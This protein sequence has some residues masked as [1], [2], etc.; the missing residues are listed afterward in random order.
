MTPGEVEQHLF[1]F[2]TE[3]CASAVKSGNG[4]V[5]AVEDGYAA[6]PHSAS[7]VFL[8]VDAVAAHNPQSTFRNATLAAML[9]DALLPTVGVLN[10]SAGDAEAW[11]L[12]AGYARDRVMAYQRCKAAALY[13]RSTSVSA[14]AQARFSR[15]SD[16]VRADIRS[17]EEHAMDDTTTRPDVDQ[18]NIAK[19]T[20]R[21]LRHEFDNAPSLLDNA[22]ATGISR[23]Q[24]VG[25]STGNWECGEGSAF[26]R[27]AKL[28]TERF[29]AFAFAPPDHEALMAANARGGGVRVDDAIVSYPAYVT[30]HNSKGAIEHLPAMETESHPNSVIVPCA[31]SLLCELHSLSAKAGRNHVLIAHGIKL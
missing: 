13:A 25:L 6:Q 3:V 31:A 18:F 20:A 23:H 11:A 19:R 21:N 5:L 1:E 4:L 15:L 22:K 9:D 28:G 2:A 29:I 12:K 14:E 10:A 30:V 26:D 8:R 7:D 24:I 17:C 27:D 16:D